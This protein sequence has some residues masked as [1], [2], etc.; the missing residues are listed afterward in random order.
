MIAS[1]WGAS[2]PEIAGPVVSV[3]RATMTMFSGP[4][5]IVLELSCSADAFSAF[6]HPENEV[7]A[8]ASTSI[9]TTNRLIGRLRR[10]VPVHLRFPPP[11]LV[12]AVVASAEAVEA[13]AFAGSID[14]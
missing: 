8:P 10:V 11:F 3:P 4:R 6:P 9:D 13:A 5:T 1:R 2:E 14:P 7:A 12:V